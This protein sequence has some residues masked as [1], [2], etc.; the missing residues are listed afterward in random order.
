MY[1]YE[2]NTD[3]QDQEKKFAIGFELRVGNWRGYTRFPAL[4][5]SERSEEWRIEVC[6][7]KTSQIMNSWSKQWKISLPQTHLEAKLI[8][9]TR[10]TLCCIPKMH[11]K[12]AQCLYIERVMMRPGCNIFLFDLA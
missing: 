3:K 1:V 4:K 7:V 11:M 10:K 5:Y 12:K 6:E 2:I 8:L 9:E